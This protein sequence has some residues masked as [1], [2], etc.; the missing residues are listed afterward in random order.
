MPLV[1]KQKYLPSAFLSPTHFPL[2]SPYSFL[3]LSAQI[4][5][6]MIWIS[7]LYRTI[8]VE[9]LWSIAIILWSYNFIIPYRFFSVLSPVSHLY[10]KCF[11][12][13]PSP[14]VGR[15]FTPAAFFDSR[16]SLRREQAPALRCHYNTN[17]QRKQYL[18][19]NLYIAGRRGRRPLQTLC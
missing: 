1:W 9:L 6:S 11:G 19:R 5:R 15:G 3:K 4:L 13:S 16:R 7:F 10:Y 14:F 2:E 8:I 18:C 17:R 12:Q